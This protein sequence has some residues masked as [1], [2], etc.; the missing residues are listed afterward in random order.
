MLRVAAIRI[1]VTYGESQK[2]VIELKIWRGEEYHQ[3]GLQQLSDYLDFQNLKA[4]YLLIF[5]FN[6]EKQYSAE[7]IE[8]MRTCNAGC[9]RDGQEQKSRKGEISPCL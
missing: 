8:C 2:E 7:Q 5:D 6:K 3:R 1:V 4:G 9:R